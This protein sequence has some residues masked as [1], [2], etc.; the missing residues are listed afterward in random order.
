MCW[1]RSLGFRPTSRAVADAIAFGQPVSVYP[2]RANGRL[3]LMMA[4]IGFDAARR[5]GRSIPG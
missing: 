2:G 5:R 4:G 3:F 1:Q